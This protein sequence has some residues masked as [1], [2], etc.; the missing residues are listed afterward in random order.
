MKKKLSLLTISK[1]Q[2]KDAK[3]G[4]AT[5]Y[6]L[7]KNCHNDMALNREINVWSRALAS[8]CNVIP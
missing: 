4:F 2:A 7:Y 3:G 5:S 1:E 8:T 6:C